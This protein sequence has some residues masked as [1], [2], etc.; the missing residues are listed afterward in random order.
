[1]TFSLSTKGKRDDV[2]KEIAASNLPDSAKQ[3]AANVA[4]DLA[5]SGDDKTIAVSV[6]GHAD[7]TSF[8]G[9]FNISASVEAPVTEESEAKSAA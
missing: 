4:A 9:S 5:G 6:S 3:M 1:M 8:S 7:E 2:S